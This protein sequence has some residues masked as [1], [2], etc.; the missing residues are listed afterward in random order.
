M[1]IIA[2]CIRVAYNCAS[3]RSV[4]MGMTDRQFDIHL[5][6]LLRRLE[7]ALKEAPESEEIKLLVDDIK[8][9]LERP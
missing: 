2:R 1:K 9:S 8:S 6:M 3:G 5:K 7:I 4:D